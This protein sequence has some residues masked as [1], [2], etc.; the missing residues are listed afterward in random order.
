MRKVIGVVVVA[1]VGLV[2][3][4]AAAADYITFP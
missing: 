3:A 1:G 2:F 4:L